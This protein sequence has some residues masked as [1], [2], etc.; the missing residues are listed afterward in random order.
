MDIEQ[1]LRRWSAGQARLE[2][3]LERVTPEVRDFA[4]REGHRTTAGL[5]NHVLAARVAILDGLQNGEFRFAEV[6]AELGAA[7]VDEAASRSR[8]LYREVQDVVRNA[9]AEWFSERADR[10]HAL[11]REEWLWEMLEHEIHHVGQIGLCIRL[12]GG[13]PAPIFG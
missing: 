13:E 1:F 5:V 2:S 6:D 11:N 9:Q 12:A 7:A 3:M 4:P 10:K 8:K